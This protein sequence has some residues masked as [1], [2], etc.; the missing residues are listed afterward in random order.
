MQRTFIRQFCNTAK[1]LNHRTKAKIAVAV[2]KDGIIFD[3]KTYEQNQ[4]KKQKDFNNTP[5]KDA[6]A[7]QLLFTLLGREFPENE[8]IGP[9][10]P[11]TTKEL[12]IIFKQKNLRLIYK[13]LGTSGRQVQDSLLVNNDIEKFLSKN[14]LLRA[15]QLAYVARHQGLFGYGS[16]I[17]YLL[18]NGQ[19]NDAFDIFMDL[20]KRGYKITG[21]FYN[22]IISEYADYISKKM[23]KNPNDISQNR[24]EQ[25]YRSFQKDHLGNNEEISIIHVNS[26]LKIFRV[27]KRTDLALHLFDS[28]KEGRSGKLRLK[29][30]VRTYTEMLRILANANPVKDG[31]DFV[32][33]IN[34]TERIFYNSQHN[35]HIKIDAYLVRAYVSVFA[36]CDALK[37]RARAVT[38][39]R[40]WFR[41]CPLDDIQKRVDAGQYN[42]DEWQRVNRGVK[43][44]DG[45][46]SRQLRLLDW[47][48]INASKSKRFEADPAVARMYRELCALFRGVGGP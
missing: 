46:R 21:R 48:E 42:A 5:V 22:I 9:N 18:K 10:T 36:Y 7:H 3:S 33:I 41:I 40:E 28:L 27:S 30:D 38:I 34:R 4:L 14:D 20:K 39:L 44:V 47:G 43:V 12:M 37:L 31:L 6:S 2:K 26:L 17:K 15:K 1:V 8:P 24:I 35:I 13:I 32:D 16:I 11:L 19:I 29:P 45:T 23:K 25:I